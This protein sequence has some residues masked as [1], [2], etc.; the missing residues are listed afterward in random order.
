MKKRV[1]LIFLLLISSSLSASRINEK[2]YYRPEDILRKTFEKY[3]SVSSYQDEGYVEVKPVNRTENESS[4][5][6]FRTYFIRPNLFRFELRY[7]LGPQGPEILEILSAD[8]QQIYISRNEEIEKIET[9]ET[10]IA[11]LT[12]I[13]LG[14]SYF[15][16]SLL[17]NLENFFVLSNLRVPTLEELNK[18]D[19]ENFWIIKGKHPDPN[20]DTILECWIRKRDFL[21]YKITYIIGNQFSQNRVEEIHQNISIN[22]YIPKNIFIKDMAQSLNI[23]EIN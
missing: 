13:S 2:T 14:S 7:S 11:K 15:I 10:G 16:P 6:Y 12:G 19:G 22:T 9:I 1:G 3:A 4:R 5:R 17:F 21:I 20:K 18:I 8:G 23:K